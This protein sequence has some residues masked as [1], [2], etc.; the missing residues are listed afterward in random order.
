MAEG[1]QNETV[2]IAEGDNHY[3]KVS[4]DGTLEFKVKVVS[5]GSVDVLI[6]DGIPVGFVFYY[7]DYDFIAR[8]YVD[9]EFP[10]GSEGTVYLVVDNS[11]DIGV[12][13]TGPV[14]VDVEW[15]LTGEAF[16]FLLA[17]IIPVIFLVL[18]V[19]GVIIRFKRGRAAYDRSYSG[20]DTVMEDVYLNERG[21]VI[22]VSSGPP[23]AARP[24]SEP[25]WCPGCGAE[26]RWDQRLG[27]MVCPYCQ[28]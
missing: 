12:D 7:E 11:N 17:V 4:G 26:M 13:A 28:T 2:T 20:T 23:P 5:G 19:V 15:E 3:W 9:E 27:R 22:G 24:P 25:Q 14:T 1:A 10:M 8:T 18:I 21:Q 6:T 16:A